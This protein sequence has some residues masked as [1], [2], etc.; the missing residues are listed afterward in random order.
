MPCLR[1]KSTVHHTK[2]MNLDKAFTQKEKTVQ[3]KTKN[4]EPDSEVNLPL[5]STTHSK[6][7]FPFPELP[8]VLS[9]RVFL[10]IE[11]AAKDCS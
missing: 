1:A 7:P 8:H 10:Q 3:K 2:L 6:C 4:P 9:G 11:K 5:G